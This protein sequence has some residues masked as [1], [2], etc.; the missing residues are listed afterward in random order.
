MREKQAKPA[1]LSSKQTRFFLMFQSDKMVKSL[2]TSMVLGNVPII[3]KNTLLAGK[4]IWGN[5]LRGKTVVVW[6]YEITS[7]SL[8]DHRAYIAGERFQVIETLI[9]LLRIE[10]KGL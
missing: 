1:Y 7:I 4:R 5:S 6:F 2:S 9:D 8:H 10:W 3:S